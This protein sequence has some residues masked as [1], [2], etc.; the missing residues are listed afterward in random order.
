MSNIDTMTGSEFEEFL[1]RLFKKQGYE[2]EVTQKSNDQ[3][4]DLLLQKSGQRIVVQAKRYKNNVGNNAVQQITAAK[5][6]YNCHYAMIVTNSYFTSSAKELA[7]ANDI[8]L[9]N[10]NRLEKEIKTTF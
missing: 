8:K 9:W 2:V 3:G 6:Y 10:R 7:F 5:N 1:D 4:A